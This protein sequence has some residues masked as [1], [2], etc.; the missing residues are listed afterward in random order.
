MMSKLTFTIFIF[1]IS[2]NLFS[3][4]A[5]LFISTEITYSFGQNENRSFNNEVLEKRKEVEKHT[6][7]PKD[8][9]SDL[10]TSATNIK[11]LTGVF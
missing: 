8:E 2:A 9:I 10:I 1:L 11:G 5:M 3:Q 7:I 6:I 4:N